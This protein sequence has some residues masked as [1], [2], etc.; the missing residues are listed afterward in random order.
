MQVKLLLRQHVNIPTV[1]DKTEWLGPTPSL[2]VYTENCRQKCK[3]PCC[4]NQ[5]KIGTTEIVTLVKF[6]QCNFTIWAATWQNQQNECAPSEDSDQ[7][8]HL[9]S[10]S[11]VFAVRMKKAW[12]L[13]YPLS[14]S[15]VTDQTGRMPRLIWVFAGRTVILLVLSC[16]GWDWL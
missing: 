5:N 1:A 3:F 8:G 7:S 9:P 11:R 4:G 16:S 15:E 6:Y 2:G 14:G 12:V 10:L 13:S